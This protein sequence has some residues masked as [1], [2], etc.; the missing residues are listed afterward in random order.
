RLRLP[1]LWRASARQLGR[2]PWQIGLAVLG[3]ALGVAVVVAVDLA[4]ASATVAF[5]LATEAISGRATHQVVGGP[6]GL[7]DAAYRRLVQDAGIESA[8]P[9]VE[10]SVQV[11]GAQGEKGPLLHLLGVDPFA[12]APFRPYLS[13]WGAGRGAGSGSARG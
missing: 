1:I 4:N 8:A 13:G 5:D 6:G 7:P 9:I 3:V 11:V 2:H 10:E 12:E